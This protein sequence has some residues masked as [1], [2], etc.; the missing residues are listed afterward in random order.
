MPL[1]T[2]QC[3]KETCHHVIDKIQKISDEPLKECPECKE[4]TLVKQ[5]S[6]GAII[7]MT[8]IRY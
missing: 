8:G 6:G 4:Q 5:V 1:Y 2:Y 3:S 7:K